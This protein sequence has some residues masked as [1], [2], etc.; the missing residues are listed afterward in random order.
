MFESTA[1][2]LTTRQKKKLSDGLY[3]RSEVGTITGIMGPTGAGKSI[4]LRMLSGQLQPSN[5][6]VY[7]DA[8]NVHADYNSIRGKIGYLPQAETMIPEL[9]VAASLDYRL[10]LH[11]RLG[12]DERRKRIDSTCRKLG[13]ED[14]MHILDQ[15]IGRPEWR[16]EYPSGGERRCINIA[17]ELV[18]R[19]SVLLLDEPTTGLSALEAEIIF[20]VLRSLAVERE[21]TIVL[22]IHQPSREIFQKLDE[23]I[24]VSPGG[25][26]AYSGMT[27]RVVEYLQEVSG[28]YMT[29]TQNPADFVL[30][31]VRTKDMA[32]WTT[33]QF[34]TSVGKRDRFPYL[35][36]CGLGLKMQGEEE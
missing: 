5:G 19:P 34:M 3:I 30:D 36:E 23:L 16:G 4:F 11:E 29:P 15:K 10:R 31:F 21:M 26:T 13:F 12:K 17:H 35:N 7:F 2:S 25:R 18:S 24:V 6:Q 1:L 33:R 9:K 27:S 8:V 28:V 22:T 20:K 32:D 14:K